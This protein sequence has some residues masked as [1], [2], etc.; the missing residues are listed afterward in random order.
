MT[1]DKIVASL[2]EAQRRDLTVNWDDF[3]DAE[4][5]QLPPDYPDDLVKAGFV[6]L[7]AVD[8]DDLDEAFAWDRGIEPG[9]SV[10]RLTPLGL[11]VRDHIRRST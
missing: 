5:L 11:A 8:D 10:Y 7:D 6:I 9:G 1:L 2:S 3:C 4:R